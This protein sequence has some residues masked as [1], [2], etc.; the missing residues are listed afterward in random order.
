MKSAAV[1]AA[2]WMRTVGYKVIGS[3]AGGV[4]IWSLQSGLQPLTARHVNSAS[5][6]AGL[7]GGCKELRSIMV[8]LVTVRKGGF[9]AGIPLR[10]FKPCGPGRR[11][12]LRVV[13][14]IDAASRA[15]GTCAF[16]QCSLD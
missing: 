7:I 8:S 15:R 1:G 16:S 4:D 3:V 10:G 2:V 11:F 6:T 12:H 5:A 9:S 13:A 14:T